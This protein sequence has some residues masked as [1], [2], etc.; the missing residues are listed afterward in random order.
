MHWELRNEMTLILIQIA[1]RFQNWYFGL[2]FIDRD[3][4]ED[5]LDM[6]KKILKQKVNTS[7]G[8]NSLKFQ[9]KFR[10]FPE[11]V[12]DEVIQDVTLRLLFKQV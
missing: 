11:N 4:Q 5:W 1:Y 9:F 10:Y 6:D 8:G 7:D 2:H 3:N 12:A